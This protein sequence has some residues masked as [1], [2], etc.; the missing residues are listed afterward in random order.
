M[1]T[2]S[3]TVT[4]LPPLKLLPRAH[5]APPLLSTKAIQFY[6]RDGSATGL[7]LTGKRGGPWRPQATATSSGWT[8]LL[9]QEA[10]RGQIA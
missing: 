3:D 8:S 7:W 6:A 1:T 10:A 9:R 2:E 5:T 4:E